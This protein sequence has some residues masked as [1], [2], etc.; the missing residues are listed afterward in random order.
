MD[1]MCQIF[2]FLPSFLRSLSPPFPPSSLPSLPSS[3][4]SSSSIP[5]FLP[6]Q[7]WV[8]EVLQLS[9]YMKAIATLLIQ[10]TVC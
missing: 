6:S 4:L 7:A 5:P 1:E 10:L 9:L 3:L 2:L 8:L